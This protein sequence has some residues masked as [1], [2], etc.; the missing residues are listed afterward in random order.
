[1]KKIFFSLLILLATLT[2]TTATAQKAVEARKILDKTAAVVGKKGGASASFKISSTKIG[3]TTGTIAIK[4]LKF[5]ARTPQAIVWYNG[6]T[7]W[8]YM[9]STDEVNIFTPT[10]AQQMAMNPYQFINIYKKGYTLSLVGN[11]AKSYTVRLVAQDKKRSAQ[12]MFIKVNRKT[13]VPTQVRM[14]EGGTWTTIDITGF[15]AKNQPDAVFVFNA[16]E[17]PSAEVIDLR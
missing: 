1:M 11:D 3:S 14:R 17:F 10:E 5:H 9:K 2:A 8:S 13:Y 6:K 16:K 12:E 4:G 7:Q 15:Q